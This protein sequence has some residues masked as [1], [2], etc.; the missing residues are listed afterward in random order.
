MR[1]LIALFLFIF[2]IS[3]TKS[4]EPCHYI[5]GQTSDT[6]LFISFTV[7]NEKFVYYQHNVPT[8]G[9]L[10]TKLMLKNQHVINSSYSI[11]FDSLGWDG[12]YD[13][14]DPHPYVRLNLN[15]TLLRGSLDIGDKL[16]TLSE[17]LLGSYRFNWVPSA[18]YGFDEATYASVSITIHIDNIEYSTDYLANHFG[19]SIDSLNK[20]LGN[21]SNL[22]ITSRKDV[23][24]DLELVTGEFNTNVMGAYY[25]N[26]KLYKIENGY[27][28]LLIK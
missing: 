20:Y 27:F 25:S 23:C 7:N 17:V 8:A 6:S 18:L 21:D 22:N 16:P 24:N 9:F 2:L 10:V 4:P 12:S 19:F 14:F 28:R 15:D 3:C 5:I 11:D 1:S 13:D 26:I